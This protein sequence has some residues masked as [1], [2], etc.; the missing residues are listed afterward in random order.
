VDANHAILAKRFEEKVNFPLR[1]VLARQL[2]KKRPNVF[3]SK[4]LEFF[5]AKD[6]FQKNVV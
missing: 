3:N 2:V 1:N 6:P 4:I 5:G